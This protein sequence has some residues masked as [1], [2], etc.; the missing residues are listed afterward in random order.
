MCFHIIC[1]HSISIA[2]ASR[3]IRTAR[4]SMPWPVK[5][6]TQRTAVVHVIARTTPL[7][8]ASV[9]LTE[10][11]ARPSLHEGHEEGVCGE[12]AQCFPNRS[13]SLTHEHALGR[14][15]YSSQCSRE[16]LQMPDRHPPRQTRRHAHVHG[17]DITCTLTLSMLETTA[18]HTLPS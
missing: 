16:N 8:F 18:R 13:E 10:I 5:R 11:A 14:P 17:E 4:N 1:H 12:R 3:I 9:V 7:Q 2:S 6:L 15:R